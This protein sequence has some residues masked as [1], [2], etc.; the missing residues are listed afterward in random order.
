VY[1]N[2][3]VLYRPDEL[4]EHIEVRFD[5]DTAWLTQSQIA[6]LSGVKQP[7]IS[8]HLKNIFVS[9]ELVENEVYSKMEYTTQH[10]AIE[11]EID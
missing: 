6:E 11:G 7:A 4:A 8:K 3:I 1:C 2:E 5:E 10:G 9:G